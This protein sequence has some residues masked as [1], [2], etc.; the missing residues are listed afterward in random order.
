MFVI[1]WSEKDNFA[2]E[3]LKDPQ[4]TSYSSKTVEEGRLGKPVVAQEAAISN[5]EKDYK[6]NVLSKPGR[7][8]SLVRC[9][10]TASATGV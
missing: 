9:A 8:T 4:S 5:Q 10:W 6:A 2:L 7:R 1:F 3:C